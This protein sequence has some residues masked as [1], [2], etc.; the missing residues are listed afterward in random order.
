MVN[1]KRDRNGYIKRLSRYRL[2]RSDLLAIE[3]M[4]RIYADAREMQHAGIARLPNGHR[5]MPRVAVDRYA[6]IG[7]YMPFHLSFGWNEFGVHFAGIDWIYREDSVKLFSR[8]GYPKHARYLEL[9][10]WPGIKVTFTP[11]STTI[12]AQTHYATGKELKAM[13]EAVNAIENYLMGT[14][15]TFLNVHQVKG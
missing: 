2:N 6:S 1:I 11:L 10:A 4:L 13:K 3:K 14:T 7:R 9:V 8:K 15:K 5:R 12:F